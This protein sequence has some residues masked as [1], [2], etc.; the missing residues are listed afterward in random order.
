M[1]PIILWYIALAVLLFWGTK[2]CKRKTWNEGNMSLE[3][4]KCFL[5]FCAVI[6]VFHH[7]AQRTCAGWLNPRYIR[8]GLDTFL[9]AGYPMVATFFFC[10]GFGLYKSLKTKPDFLRRFI[11]VRIIPILVPTMLT[12][13]VYLWLRHLRKI[14]LRYDNP[15]QV[16]GHETLHPYVWYVPAIITMYLIFYIGF[17][18]FKKDWAGILTVF[19]GLVAYTVF[20]IKFRYGTWWINTPHMFLVGIITAKYEKKIFESCKKFYALKLGIVI[21]LCPILIHLV[22]N[23]GEMYF[24]KFHHPYNYIYAYRANLFTCIFQVLYTFCFVA[25]YYLLSMKLRIGNKML[26]FLGKFTLELY[27]THGIFIH[28][29]GYYMIYEGVKPIHYIENMP[30]FV[31]VV[32]GLSIPAAFILSL[33]DKQIGKLLRPKNKKKNGEIEPRT[34]EE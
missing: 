31:L 10:S 2:I 17:R 32:M 11:P 22:N 8:H 30:L 9:T 27:L 3:H 28:M 23:A 12:L 4:T 1:N 33:L 14:P 15:F 5:G 25:L 7:M 16:N 19:L 6:V 20:C 26:S 29:F 18:L 24:K 34:G 21:I 13:S